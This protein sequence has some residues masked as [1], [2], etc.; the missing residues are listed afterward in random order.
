MKL[1]EAKCNNALTG[2]R[3]ST[4]YTPIAVFVGGTSGIGRQTAELLAQYT[5]GN[6]HI[7]LVARGRDAAEKILEGMVRPLDGRKVL[8]V[9]IQC[10]VALMKNA[11]AAVAEIQALLQANQLPQ[12]INFL[13]LSAGYASFSDRRNDTEEGIDHQLV[14]RYYHRFKFIRETLPLLHAAKDVGEDAKVVSCLGAGAKWPWVPKDG[15]FGYKKRKNGPGFHAP[16]VSAVYGDLAVEGFASHNPGISFTHM[17]P[18]FVRT[19]QFNNKRQISPTKWYAKFLNPIIVF[20][21]SF[22]S[23]SE[24]ES[25][26]YFL[27]ALLHGD[28]GAHWRDNRA[29]EIGFRVNGVDKEAFW[30]H[31]MEETRRRTV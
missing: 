25:A 24:E 12:K 15:D 20:F 10:D 29:K 18:W 31:S 6:V 3:L 5:N 1:S 7:I 19:Q 21:W 23:L 14:L 4:T 28:A 11:E 22:F 2:S 26:E 30:R 27:Y 16:L 8:R 17:N 9:F 13:F